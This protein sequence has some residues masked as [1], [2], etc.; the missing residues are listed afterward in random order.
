MLLKSKE[1]GHVLR[2]CVQGDPC[3]QKTRVCVSLADVPS[4]LA[5]W[6]PGLWPS[7]WRR[8]SQ[9]IQYVPAFFFEFWNFVCICV[10]LIV[11][12][13]E[14]DKSSTISVTMEVETV[15]GDVFLTDQMPAHP[16]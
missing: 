4:S 8:L 16:G 7:A 5:G 10:H 3:H 12:M 9:S 1:R 2:L 11:K 14:T 6:V 15:V 13:E